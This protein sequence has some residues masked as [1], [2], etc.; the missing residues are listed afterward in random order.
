MAD[1]TLVSDSAMRSTWAKKRCVI[2]SLEW[3]HTASSRF[4]PTNQR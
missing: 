1:L 4:M 3:F 2:A